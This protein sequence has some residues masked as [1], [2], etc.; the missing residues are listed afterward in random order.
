MFCPFV[1][2]NVSCLL[3]I[4]NF[5]RP[6]INVLCMT[7]MLLLTVNITRP[8][9]KCILFVVDSQYYENWAFMR[10]QERSSMMPMMA[11]G[12]FLKGRR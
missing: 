12:E 6:E 2:I 5:M 9:I 7:T 10:D 8:E 1:P 3:L 11:A 4:V